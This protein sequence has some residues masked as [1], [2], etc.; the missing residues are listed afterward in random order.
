MVAE[1][2]M[3]R[4]QPSQ[5]DVISVIEI[6][7]IGPIAGSAGGGPIA[8]SAGGDMAGGVPGCTAAGVPARGAFWVPRTL[9]GLPGGSAQYASRFAGIGVVSVG[10]RRMVSS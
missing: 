4:A 3:R 5:I 8:G 9:V 10:G 6:M 1:D 2:G 7:V